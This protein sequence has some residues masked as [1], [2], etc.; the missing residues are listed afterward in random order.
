MVGT[1]VYFKTQQVKREEKLW[2]VLYDVEG[3]GGAGKL[4]RQNNPPTQL[5]RICVYIV[6]IYMLCV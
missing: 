1:I 2:C 6:Y 5:L 3:A 4:E